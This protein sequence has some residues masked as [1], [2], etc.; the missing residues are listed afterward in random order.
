MHI[1][2]WAC[3]VAS[4]KWKCVRT[5]VRNYSTVVVVLSLFVG[6]HVLVSPCAV[7]DGVRH[8]LLCYSGWGVFNMLA[9]VLCRR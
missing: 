3:L 2:K 5:V 9:A 6:P 1:G 7:L 8:Q 4:R